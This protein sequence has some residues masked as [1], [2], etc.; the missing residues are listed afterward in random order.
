[1]KRNFEFDVQSAVRWHGRLVDLHNDYDLDRFGTDLN[2][3]E[4]TL[5]FRRNEYAVHPEALPARVRLSC[6]GNL[7][8]AFNDLCALAAPVNDEGIEVAYFDEHCD[9]QSLTDEKLAK[10]Q[11]PR[12]LRLEFINGL[13]VRVFCDEAIFEALE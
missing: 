5:D 9:W 3:T 11:E 13:T 6:T 7:K 4:V 8:L 1:M 10:T 12:G 2:G